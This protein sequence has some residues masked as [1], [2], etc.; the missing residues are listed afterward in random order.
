MSDNT[1]EEAKPKK[2]KGLMF[3]VVLG[4]VLIA[5]GG[6]GTFA[7]MASGLLGGDHAEAEDNS[8]KL[9]EKGEEDPY[10]AGE[11]EEGEEVVHGEGG[12]EYR[13]AYY[14]FAESF[15]SNLANSDALLQTT[16]AASTRR[17]GRV[18][19]WLKEHELAVRSAM[20]IELAN[21]PEQ[22]VLTPEGKQALQKRLTKAINDV[23]V[24]AEGFGGVDRVYFRDFIVQ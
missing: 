14:T 13:T 22:D 17:D 19:M 9:I 11:E 18:L 8:P 2:G 24:D 10:S 12:S 23:L 16:L 3:K 7:L 20:L 15:T 21:T 1:N 5:A 6:G 4:V